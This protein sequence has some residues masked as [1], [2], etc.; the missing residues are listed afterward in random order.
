MV[1]AVTFVYCLR[2]EVN[3]HVLVILLCAEMGRL[4]NIKVRYR[5]G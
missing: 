4:V 3:V 1:V 2:Q 5:E